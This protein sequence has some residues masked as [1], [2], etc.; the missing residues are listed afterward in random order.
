MPIAASVKMFVKPFFPFT[1]VANTGSKVQQESDL[2]L[3]GKSKGKSNTANASG[4][5]LTV[6]TTPYC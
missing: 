4:P 3:R 6:Y 2:V 1:P 5:T